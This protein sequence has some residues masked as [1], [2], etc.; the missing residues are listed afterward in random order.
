MTATRTPFVQTHQALT[1]A[2]ASAATKAMAK[3][4]ANELASKIAFTVVAR[5]R[6]TTSVNVKSDGRDLIVR[7][8][9]AAIGILLAIKASENV[10][11]ATI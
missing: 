7:Q 9:V 10:T 1:S 4:F 5:D 3:L 6:R 8:I 2:S 11:G